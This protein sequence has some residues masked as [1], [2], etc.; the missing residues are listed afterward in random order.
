MGKGRLHHLQAHLRAD[1]HE[2]CRFR[3]KEIGNQPVDGPDLHAWTFALPTADSN[4]PGAHGIHPATTSGAGIGAAA[5]P[6]R[7][8]STRQGTS[9]C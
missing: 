7:G 5:S 9:L 6:F 8:W 3:E 4:M 1:Q 2:Q